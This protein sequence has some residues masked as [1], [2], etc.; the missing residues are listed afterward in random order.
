MENIIP[1]L[2]EGLTELSSFSPKDPIEFLV[3]KLISQNSFIKDH[4]KYNK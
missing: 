1:I 2:T 3:F 4:L